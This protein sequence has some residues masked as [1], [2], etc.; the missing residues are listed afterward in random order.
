M[1]NILFGLWVVAGL[2]LFSLAVG[3]CATSY[4]FKAGA[5]VLTGEVIGSSEPVSADG[6]ADRAIC[7][8]FGR[9]A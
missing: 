6:F 7:N 8:A 3:Y 2:L 4:R 5:V 1:R 9:T